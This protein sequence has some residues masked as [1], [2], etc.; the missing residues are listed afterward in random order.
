MT[1]PSV[2]A[3]S[4]CLPSQTTVQQLFS[5]AR[6][7]GVV[8]DISLDPVLTAFLSMES[9]ASLLHQYASLQRGMTPEQLASFRHNVS[10][11]LGGSTRVR[12]GGV[13]VVALALSVLFDLVAKKVGDDFRV[14][15]QQGAT[16]CL[17]GIRRSSRIGRMIHSYLR[18]IPGV[19]ND[20]EGMAETTELYDNW[21]KLE[22]IDHY[23]R[24]TNKKRMGS[25][26]MRQ[27]LAGAAVHMHMRIHQVRLKSVPLGSAESLRLS[28]RTAF[29]QLV[30]DYASYLR[31]NIRETPPSGTYKPN[32]AQPGERTP[33]A[34]TFQRL[35][36]HG[37]RKEPSETEG[38]GVAVCVGATMGNVSL[39][40]PMND[41]NGTGPDGHNSTTAANQAAAFSGGSNE[42]TGQTGP[43]QMD[44]NNDVGPERGAASVLS[45]VGGAAQ[46]T[47]SDG[48]LVIEAMRN[49]SHGVRHR[50]CESPVIEQALATLISEAQDLEESRDFFLYPRPLL[51]NLLGQRADFDLKI[52]WRK[53]I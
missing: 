13:G 32:A 28:Y 29:A 9:R 25:E 20:P 2:G 14:P 36:D 24:M 38:A 44:N 43:K 18:L 22:L 51:D 48:L 52:R 42:V 53:T 7:A 30:Q 31:R 34:T 17:F 40:C 39:A 27:W 26:A 45:G 46:P 50:A 33:A 23:E 19:A 10:G 15:K 3:T 41:L 1:L 49:V 5:V 4:L 35:T 8:P 6:D 47:A 37:T 21:L 11:E 16:G 12:H